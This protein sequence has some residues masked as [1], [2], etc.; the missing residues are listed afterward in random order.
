MMSRTVGLPSLCSIVGCAVTCMVRIAGEV[1][2][3]NPR[4]MLC[5]IGAIFSSCAS[6]RGAGSGGV[7]ITWET[8]AARM[9]V[10]RR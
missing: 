10:S 7:V 4:Y 2:L 9:L 3:K 8:P 5:E 6:A 1:A